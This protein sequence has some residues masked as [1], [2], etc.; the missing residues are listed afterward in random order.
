MVEES[1]NIEQ[2][3]QR[4]LNKIKIKYY[5]EIGSSSWYY[6]KGFDEWDFVRVKMKRGILLRH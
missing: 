4:K 3:C 1:L 5:R 6:W 2:F